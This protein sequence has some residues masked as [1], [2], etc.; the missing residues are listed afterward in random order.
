VNTEI[1]HNCDGSS[2]ET[3]FDD[4]GNEIE[5]RDFSENSEM[6][7]IIKYHYDNSLALVGW[8]EFRRGVLMYKYKIESGNK[9]MLVNVYD[10]N[11][12]LIETTPR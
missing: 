8:D 5:V 4:N 2:T 7:R 12:Y 9:G 3:D 6:L 10:K 1:I 11:G